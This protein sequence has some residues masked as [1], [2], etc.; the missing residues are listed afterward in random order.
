ML[1]V[2]IAF[3]IKE[4]TSL[5]EE[6]VGVGLENCC[7]R[8]RVPADMR[9][10]LGAL[11][12]SQCCSMMDRTE[13]PETPWVASFDYSLASWKPPVQDVRNGERHKDRPWCGTCWSGSEM[14][15]AW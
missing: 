14:P 3:F 13:V 15:C 12:C 6:G 4:S 11:A 1:A 9:G 8:R 5:A 2:A 10:S 7:T